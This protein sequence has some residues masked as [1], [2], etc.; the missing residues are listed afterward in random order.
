MEYGAEWCLFC[1]TGGEEAAF[2]RARCVIADMRRGTASGG[3]RGLWPQTVPASGG[4]GPLCGDGGAVS[5]HSVPET[6]VRRGGSGGYP[7]SGRSPHGIA[8]RRNP[9]EWE[10]RRTFEHK[11][12][13]DI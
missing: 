6:G 3:G 9:T 10:P 11:N 5:E 8:A 2:D 13:K 7:E 1:M 4:A 12:R